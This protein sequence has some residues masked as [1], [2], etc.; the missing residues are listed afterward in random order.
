MTTEK[1]LLPEYLRIVAQ[2]K[3]TPK[4]ELLERLYEMGKMNF[5][6]A[7]H[8]LSVCLE[9][10]VGMNKDDALA[11]EY[12]K[13]AA[14]MKNPA[15]MHNMECNYLQ[16]R[17]VERDPYKALAYFTDAARAGYIMSAHCAGWLNDKGDDGVSPNGEWA[18]RAYELAAKHGYAPSANN[19]GIFYLNGRH[20][21]PDPVKAEEWLKKAADAGSEEA[22]VNLSRLKELQRQKSRNPYQDIKSYARIWLQEL[23]F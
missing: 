23:P 3:K 6:P 1:D 11:F 13:V 16:G 12:C 17:H 10:G 5:P 19:L 2:I 18:R 7:I 4:K 15:A 21:N 22:R 14:S 9:K 8:T 20:V